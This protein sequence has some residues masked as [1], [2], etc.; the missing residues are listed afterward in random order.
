[1]RRGSDAVPPPSA[2]R[3]RTKSAAATGGAAN[4]TSRLEWVRPQIFPPNGNHRANFRPFPAP[5]PQEEAPRL[6][7]GSEAA[8]GPRAILR[9]S[10]F[11]SPLLLEPFLHRILSS[12]PSSFSLSP[13]FFPFPSTCLPS[14]F[15]VHRA[16]TL[17]R[18]V[19]ARGGKWR[20]QHR[21]VPSAVLK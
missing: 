10:L 1:M 20:P 16:T 5:L 7:S 19:A 4:P 6:F 12:P 21:Y 18:P 17:S 15:T 9:L 11:R 8:G 14:Y 13:P 3:K 2:P